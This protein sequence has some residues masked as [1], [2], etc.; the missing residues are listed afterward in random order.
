MENAFAVT[1]ELIG[2][3][4]EKVEYQRMGKKMMVCLI[5]TTNGHEVVG[6]SGIVDHRNFNEQVGKEWAF[7]DAQNNLSRLLAYQVQQEMFN[8]LNK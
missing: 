1:Q 2:N 7:M 6:W 4:I 5:T 3:T 8:H